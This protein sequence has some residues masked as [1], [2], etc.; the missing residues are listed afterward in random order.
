MLAF[1]G[2]SAALG[3]GGGVAYYYL[4]ASAITTG[5]NL[6]YRGYRTLKVLQNVCFVA[7]TPVWTKDGI[8]PIEEITVGDEVLSYNETTKR[9]EYKTVVQT[10]KKFSEDVLSVSI[11]GET[12][13]LGVT[14]NHPFYVRIHRARDNTSTD[15]DDEGKWLEAGKL[16]VGNE[17]KLASG[18]WAKV[19]KIERRSVGEAVY[20]FEAADNHNYFVG[21]LGLLVHNEGDCLPQIAKAVNSNLPHAAQRAVERGFFG[22]LKEAGDALRNLSSQIS[23]NGWPQG[24]IRDT[25][26]P[27]RVLVPLKDGAYAVYQVA[28]NGTAKLKTVLTAK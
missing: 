18:D 7:G 19:L 3:T 2:L 11:E 14:P 25:A 6:A 9:V 1:F 5:T 8:K 20:N 17:I 16:K 22:S 10:F 27:D 26:H 4:G 13:P 15:D 12:E 24:T 23:K 21:Y 28:A